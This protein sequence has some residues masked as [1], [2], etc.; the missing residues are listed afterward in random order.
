[1]AFFDKFPLTR[2]DI[3]KSGNTTI[4]VDILKRI[5]F[6][7]SV[8]NESHYYQN[9]TI[10]DGETPEIVSFKFYGESGL[11]WILLLLNETIDPYF[12]WPLSNDSLENFNKKKYEGQAFYFSGDDLYFDKNTEVYVSS[13]SGTKHKEIRGLVKEWDATYRKLVLY[14]TEGTFLVGDTVSGTSSVGTISRLVDIHSQAVHHF[15]DNN[16]DTINPLGTPPNDDGIQVVVGQTGDSPYDVTAATFGNSVLWSY[17]TSNDESIT[18][19]SVVTN[20]TYENDLNESKRSIKV[21]Q[22]NLLDGII[23]D[24]EKVIK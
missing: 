18:T 21:L 9:Y 3:D 11:H 24:F 1:M 12:Q 20:Q 17:V 7:E 22:R 10:E 23:N 5:N 6:R 16:G 14:N 19:H 2:Y 8:R 4:S 13:R 15:K